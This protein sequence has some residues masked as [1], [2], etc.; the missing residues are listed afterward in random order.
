VTYLDFDN[1]KF[2]RTELNSDEMLLSDQLKQLFVIFE[3]NCCCFQRL[4]KRICRHSYCSLFGKLRRREV[5]IIK[6]FDLR[7]ALQ[8]ITCGM[9]MQS[10]SNRIARPLDSRTIF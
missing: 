4:G 10:S 7:I 1:C 9:L 3:C 5:Y 8:A 6:Y 2:R